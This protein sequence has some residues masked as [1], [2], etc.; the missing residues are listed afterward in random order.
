[1]LKRV[2]SS[3]K[4]L[5]RKY[6]RLPQTLDPKKLL[7]FILLKEFHIVRKI[8][9]LE[10]SYRKIFKRGPKNGR[11][12]IWKKNFLESIPA[13][14]EPWSK[15]IAIN[16]KLNFYLVFL[17][18]KLFLLLHEFCT[19]PKEGGSILGKKTSPKVSS[20]FPNLDP[21]KWLRYRDMTLLIIWA[22]ETFMRKPFKFNGIWSWG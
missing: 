3:G 2:V 4:W 15:E 11:I 9:F 6:P 12:F 16:H 22:G 14:P 18:I 19:N 8:T 10:K 7:L 5:P 21:K 1:M 20:P 13:F 17:F